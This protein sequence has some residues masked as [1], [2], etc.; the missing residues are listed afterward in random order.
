MLSWR[1]SI[2]SM[3]SRD[4]MRTNASAGIPTDAAASLRIL[5]STRM[6][7]AASRP[8]LNATPLPDFRHRD[9]IC[10][11]TSGRD[12]KITPSIPMGQR[13]WN[14]VSPSSRSSSDMTSPTGS[15]RRM[16]SRIPSIIPSILASSIASLLNIDFEIS[17]AST[18][19]SPLERSFELASR[20]SDLWVSS[21]SAMA[22][23]A[24]SL[25]FVGTDESWMEAVLAALTSAIMSDITTAHHRPLR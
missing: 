13:I 19:I 2:L 14:R 9:M 16:T 4:S 5:K 10:G 12:S 18:S 21:A 1:P 7:S 6:D 15:A 20:I 11:T 17:P 3:S 24:A 25:T 23:R 8:P 22:S